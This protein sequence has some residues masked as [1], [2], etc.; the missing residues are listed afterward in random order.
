MS[1]KPASPPA[2]TTVAPAPAAEL[3]PWARLSLWAAVV[4][5]LALVFGLYLEPAFMQEMANMVWAC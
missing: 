3:S 4:L 1:T 5:V 2:A